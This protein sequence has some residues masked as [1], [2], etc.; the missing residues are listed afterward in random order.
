MERPL[1]NFSAAV[2]EMLGCSSCGS[3][4]GTHE[5]IDGQSVFT[6][7]CGKVTGIIG[8]SWAERAQEL[9]LVEHW[10]ILA[11]AKAWLEKLR[12]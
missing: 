1:T 7:V 2:F 10:S 8:G 4:N 11:S 9:V 6:C 5:V 3:K 12:S